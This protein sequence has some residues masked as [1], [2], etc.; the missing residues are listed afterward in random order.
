[1]GRKILNYSPVKVKISFV[2]TWSHV[3]RGNIPREI[4]ATTM[5]YCAMWIQHVL[6]P[7]PLVEKEKEEGGCLRRRIDFQEAASQDEICYAILT[8]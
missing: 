5:Q 1:M 8:T 2:S 7:I 6:L 4:A 3:F